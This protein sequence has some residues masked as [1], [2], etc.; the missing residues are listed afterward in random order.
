MKVNKYYFT[1][2]SIYYVETPVTSI[3]FSNLCSIIVRNDHDV[4]MK[5]VL[6]PK[7]IYK[8][9]NRTT[10]NEQTKIIVGWI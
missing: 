7:V 9:G 5:N 10:H 3:L 1:H 8:R 6:N 4:V 2:Y